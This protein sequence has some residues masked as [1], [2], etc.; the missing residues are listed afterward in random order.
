MRA[1]H[2]AYARGLKMEF[3][4]NWNDLANDADLR[5]RCFDALENAAR[6][7]DRFARLP[8]GHRALKGHIGTVFIR[9]SGKPTLQLKK[10]RLIVTFDPDKGYVGR[11]S[12]RAIAHALHTIF[13]IP[14]NG[15]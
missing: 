7:I 9:G 10:N 11:A 4:A 3:Q 8:A 6:G 1:H 2:L 5:A 15:D 13:R 14:N 12:S